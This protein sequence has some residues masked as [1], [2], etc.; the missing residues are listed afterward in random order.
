MRYHRKNDLTNNHKDKRYSL[1]TSINKRY[2]DVIEI[3]YVGYL[4][5]SMFGVSIGIVVPY[6]GAIWLTVLASSAILLFNWRGDQRN[7]LILVLA[8]SGTHILTQIVLYDQSL[9]SNYVIDYFWWPF[10]TLVISTLMQRQGFFKR[11]ILYMTIPVLIWSPFVIYQ[12]EAGILRVTLD[13]GNSLDNSNTYAQWFGFCILGLWQW[14]LLKISRNK[15]IMLRYGSFFGFVLALRAISRGFVI[16]LGIAF[17]VGL[18]KLK[19]TRILAL[20]IVFF[21]LFLFLTSQIS[22]FQQMWKSYNYRFSQETSRLIVLPIAKEAIRNN[23]IWGYGVSRIRDILPITPHNEIILLWISSGILPIIFYFSLI[24][25]VAIRSVR[26]GRH[27][28]FIDPLPFVIY[29]I[30]NIQLSNEVLPHLW[31]I[32]SFCYVFAISDRLK[33]FNHTPRNI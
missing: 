5:Y 8:I 13:A 11:L 23:P 7:H 12:N 20:V 21:G 26:I 2:Y 4:I 31:A 14:S 19:L 18:R 3:S 17:V 27:E 28:R 6:L 15:R 9:T 33:M 10:I 16:S 24:V 29:T 32:S 30:I 1:S 25:Y 22:F